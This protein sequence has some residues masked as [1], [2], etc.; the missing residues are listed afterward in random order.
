MS[1]GVYSDYKIKVTT[2]Y[3]YINQEDSEP[4][5]YVYSKDR[6]YTEEIVNGW[7]L[8]NIISMELSSDETV[9]IT[10]KGNTIVINKFCPHD[11]T[12]SDTEIKFNRVKQ[13][14]IK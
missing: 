14:I 7:A 12:G 5:D 9:N 4:D 11:G 6:N 13:K 3:S 8:L 1:I 10:I 2:E